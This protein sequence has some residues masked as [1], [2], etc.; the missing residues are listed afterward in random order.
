MSS[1]GLQASGDS[2]RKFNPASFTAGASIDELNLAPPAVRMLLVE[3]DDIVSGVL[4]DVLSQ[5]GFQV[6]AVRHGQ[7]AIETV[8]KTRADILLVDY[9]LPDL[10]GIT[11][12][13]RVREDAP[14]MVGIVMTGHGTIEL[15]IK[16]MRAGAFDIL[17]KPFEPDDVLT[18]VK[19][20]VEIQ[21][22]RY[23]NGLLKHTVLKM[24][25]VQP[26]AYR[27]SD[28]AHP[29]Q[30]AGRSAG[31]ADA[32]AAAYQRGVVDGE[33]R[34]RERAAGQQRQDAVLAAVARRLDEAAAAWSRQ[35]EEQVISLAIEIARK[36]VRQ[37]AD[38][39]RDLVVMQAREAIAHVRDT[40]ELHIRVHPE[41][42]PVVE[43]ARDILADVC[44]GPVVFRVDADPS[45]SRGGCVIETATCLVDATLDTQM[46]RLAE[47]LTQKVSDEA[48]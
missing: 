34:G 25:G 36:I 22:L 38:E 24:A 8:Q 6:T 46:A 30:A 18:A 9:C 42:V 20:V 19:R 33:R 29:T 3:D 39:K 44:E 4:L 14:H 27:L 26:Q 41:D 37:C 17:L 10:D 28:M 1:L 2:P 45:I 43:E 35:L 12:L 47:G 7:T 40:K 21:R 13:Q 48:E 23:E 11:V 31:T 32:A 15:A 16:A 5:E